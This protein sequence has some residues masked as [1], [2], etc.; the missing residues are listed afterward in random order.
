MRVG[1]CEIL[2]LLEIC[3]SMREL[4]QIHGLMITASHIRDIIPLSRLVDFCANS[5]SGDP[6]YAALIFLHIGRPSVYIWNSLIRGR[7]N[8][9]N[10]DEA[11]SMY[12]KMQRRGYSPDHFTFPFV[13]KAC[14]LTN[15]QNYG[16]CVHDRI[17]KTGFESDLY[18]SISLMHMYASCA[19]MEATAQL[20]DKIPKRNV[21]AW[22]TLI[23]GY[24]NNN[25]AGEAVKVFK[26]MEVQ[27]V[28]PNDITMVNVLVACAQARDLETGRLIHQ[29]VCQSDSNVILSTAIVDMYAKCGSLKLAR[30]LFDKMPQRNIVAWNSM[31]GAYNQYDRSNEALSLF[32]DMQY[33]GF[34]PDETT[35]LS[36]LGA[37]AHHGA[38]SLGQGIHAYIEKTHIGTHVVIG[39]SLMNMYAKTGETQSALQIFN[40]L[41]KKDVTAW[42]SMIIGLAMHGRGGE[43]LT[44]FKEME[45][46]KNVIPD[47]I[48]YIG[49]LCACSH[50][51]LVNEGQEHFHSM[52]N[53]YGITATIPHYGCMVDLLSRAG[54]LTEAERLIESMPIEPNIAIWSALLNGCEVHN[55][56]S[57]ADRVGNQI[58][59][60]KPQGGGVY[61]LLSNIYAKAGRWQAVKMARELMRLKRLQKTHGCSY[62]EAKSL[63]IPMTRG[64]SHTHGKFEIIGRVTY[65]D[66]GSKFVG[67][68][69]MCTTWGMQ[70]RST[71][72]RTLQVAAE[73]LLRHFVFYCH[74]M[75]PQYHALPAIPISISPYCMLDSSAILRRQ[76]FLIRSLVGYSNQTATKVMAGTHL[77]ADAETILKTITPK[78][79]PNL[80]KGQA[81]NIAIIGG[82]REYTGAPYFAAISALKIGADLSHVFCTKDAATVIKS[83]SPEIIVHPV[84][85]ESY[86]I[87]EGEKRSISAKVLT[88]VSKWMERFDCLVVGPGLG[89]DPF[90]LECVSEILKHARQLKIPFVV[91]GDGLFLVTNNL[92]LVSGYHLA[93]LTP[94]VNEYKRLVQKVLNCEVSDEGP[95]E[96]LLSLAR[97]IGGPTILR[98]GKSD[99]IS[100]G[101]TVNMVSTFGSPRRCGGQGDILSGSV[102]VFSSWAC[103]QLPAAKESSSSTQNPMV[104]GCIGASALLRKAASVAFTT[105]KRATLTTDIIECLGKSLEDICPAS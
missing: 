104:L 60:L 65:M 63:T 92:D 39:T 12:K 94:N 36:V 33:A 88:E 50:A 56:V 87:R 15:D 2:H 44:L 27:G 3:R 105:Q 76:H 11:L 49:V 91:D 67:D 68:S 84:L 34:T 29:R 72:S 9:N 19:D 37:C 64:G 85:E 71:E 98:K 73:A 54:R 70:V 78:L 18:A 23:A 32:E 43:A 7:S 40:G 59:Q 30:E 22:T 83:Y 21:V 61:V 20:F 58:L 89:R 8:G 28:Q 41:E 47:H 46:D 96:E 42:T 53:L 25:R 4:K 1:S 38:L 66:R 52:R 82:C 31:I 10:P 16:M 57:L 79:D 24:V 62:I 6:D 75:R 102:A 51:G 74:R 90:L 69:C 99:L 80:H 48:T 95:S 26:E 77:E 45:R 101:K 86:N 5:D 100:D 14:A 35:L 103:Q 97:R 17:V 13:L 81:G 55:N 93:V